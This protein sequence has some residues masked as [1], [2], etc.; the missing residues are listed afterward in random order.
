MRTD[1]TGLYRAERHRAEL[2][3]RA[4]AAGRDHAA[5]GQSLPAAGDRRQ[6][7]P[8]RN[9]RH[10]LHPQARF[11]RSTAPTAR[12]SSSSR[13]I[14][15]AISSADSAPCSACACPNTSKCCLNTMNQ[16]RRHP[17][18]RRTSPPS[19][20]R[21][22]PHTTD[23]AAVYADGN[24]FDST[25]VLAGRIRTPTACPAICPEPRPRRR[26]NTWAPRSFPVPE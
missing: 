6:P 4:G 7:D 16:H 9:G 1:R 22:N 15:R 3:A 18:Q 5:H 14:M 11:T 24:D 25:L 17:A 12:P 20:P 26:T 2:P 19:S 8:R 21:W 13:R 23:A 10:A